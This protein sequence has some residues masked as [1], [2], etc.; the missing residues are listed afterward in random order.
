MK[1]WKKKL[2]IG[3]LKETSHTLG[4]A[5]QR[6]PGRHFRLLVRTPHRTPGR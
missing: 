4:Q 3:S 5:G 2:R 1:N 6:K